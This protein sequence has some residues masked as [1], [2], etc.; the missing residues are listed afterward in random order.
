[1]ALHQAVHL[2]MHLAAHQSL[3][4]WLYINLLTANWRR[5]VGRQWV[6]DSIWLWQRTIDWRSIRVHSRPDGSSGW[7]DLN[8]EQRPINQDLMRLWL[9]SRRLLLLIRLRL[10][11]CRQLI[12]TSVQTYDRSRLLICRR[13]IKLLN[14]CNQL[15]LCF[16]PRRLLQLL[17]SLSGPSLLLTSLAYSQASAVTSLLLLRASYCL[18]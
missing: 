8:V 4:L 14:L 16:F 15:K 12:K 18:C 3:H 5:L 17:S 7:S 13:S 11:T 10:C 1:M 6:T 9:D 2:A